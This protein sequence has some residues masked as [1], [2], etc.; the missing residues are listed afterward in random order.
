MNYKSS[1]SGIIENLK[2]HATNDYFDD[3]AYFAPP[4]GSTKTLRLWQK[5]AFEKLRGKRFTLVAAFCGSGKSILQVA[6]AIDD[7]IQS[8]YTQKQLI[9]VPQSHIGA[10]MIESDGAGCIS[11]TVDGELYDWSVQNNYCTVDANNVIE[12][13][14]AWLLA[15]A[16]KLALHHAPNEVTGLNAVATHS[17]LCLVWKELSKDQKKQAIQN[18]TLR[19]DEAHHIKGVFDF[20]EDELSSAQ[21]EQIKID[22]TCLGDICRYIFNSHVTT[23]KISLTTATPYRGDG[24]S[25]LSKSVLDKFTVYYLD[26]VDHF[27]TLGIKDFTLEYEEY[28]ENPIAL[29]LD[30]VRAEPHEKHLIVIP[31]MNQKWRTETSLQELIKGLNLIVPSER[32]LDLVT[33]GAIQD[34]RKTLLLKEPKTPGDGVESFDVVITCMLGRE[35]TDWCPCSRLHNTACE[36]SITLAV[37]TGG[38]VFR[39]Y[40]LEDNG[41]IVGGKTKVKLVYYV[42]R[43][44]APKLGMTKRELLSD[45]SNAL[46]FCMQISEMCHPILIPIT[47]QSTD[48]KFGHKSSPSH[49]SLAKVFGD[50]YQSMKRMLFQSA[51]VLTGGG[52]EDAIDNVIDVYGVTEN[53]T[54]IKDGLRCLVLRSVSSTLRDLGIDI[55]FIRELGGFDRIIEDY[56]LKGRSIFFGDYNEHD[57]PIIRSIVECNDEYMLNIYLQ[58][59]GGKNALPNG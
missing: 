43:F 3:E 54:D 21:Q 29:V 42:P 24:K 50:H 35:G 1:Q 17:A 6:L 4:S 30:H 7:V 58:R 48:S 12:S 25:I 38:R 46:L 20:E 57:W 36:N 31:P 41:L 56:D 2:I 52:I 45:R 22:S 8:G 47:N 5:D 27:K 26:W 51:D 37:Q 59:Y 9:V 55:Q 14:K 49:V 23:S 18:L 39:R 33:Q 16:R 15:D 53:I 10:G 19:I 40:V 11:I 32:I 34:A 28:D 44:V 13:L